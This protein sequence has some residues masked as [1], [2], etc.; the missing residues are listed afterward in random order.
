MPPNYPF[1]PLLSACVGVKMPAV[2]PTTLARR[3]AV[4]SDATRQEATRLSIE[5]VYVTVIAFWR[6]YWV[7]RGC[8]SSGRRRQRNH[9]SADHG[10]AAGVCS[11]ISAALGRLWRG[12]MLC[13]WRGE[14]PRWLD[15]G[16]GPV[17]H[18]GARA[19]ST[20]NGNISALRSAEVSAFFAAMAAH[21]ES[22]NPF[23]S[24]GASPTSPR[25][26]QGL[27]RSVP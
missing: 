15:P 10:A 13:L 6:E 8:S 16:G 9:H 3:V 14:D 27:K 5:N 2:D 22:P 1:W 4:T 23:I 11:R 19:L 25:G 20:L 24:D 12:I 17:F 21:I 26:W 7:H 18:S